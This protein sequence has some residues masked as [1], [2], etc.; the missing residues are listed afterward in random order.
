MTSTPHSHQWTVTQNLNRER[1][2]LTDVLT[3]KNLVNYYEIFHQNTK[4]YPFSEPHEIFSKID[5][6]L[7]VIKSQQIQRKWNKPCI[8][9]DHCGVK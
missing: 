5:T 1:R 9:S 8:I 6:L 7:V 2:E 3:K 4:E